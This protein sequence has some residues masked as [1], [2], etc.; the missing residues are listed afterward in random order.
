MSGV[1]ARKAFFNDPSLDMVEGYKILMGGAPL[2]EDI[3]LDVT[4]VE[5]TSV[6]IKRLLLLLRKDRITET[7]PVLLEDVNRRMMDWGRE[8]RINPFKEVYDLVFQMTVRMATCQEL[9]DDPKKIEELTQH[10]WNLEKSATPFA[11]L[12]PWFPGSSKR[13]KE[14][15]TLALYNLLLKLVQK[16]RDASSALDPIDI[17]IQNGDSDDAII[18]TILGIIF[19][20]VINTGVNSCWALLQL[21]TNPEWK[22]KAISELNAVITNHT[23]TLS[24]EPFHKQLASI[25]LSAWEEELPSLDLIIRETLRFTMTGAAIRR[26]LTND[27]EVN[28][29]SIKTGDF[30]TYSLY[31]AHMNPNIYS[32]PEKFDPSR[33]EK[34]REED[35]K[36]NFG[37]LGWGV[38][39]HPCA[40]MKIAK[41]EIKLILAM[42]LIGYD[43]TLVDKDDKYPMAL[44]KPD[45]NDIQQARPL[46]EPVYMKF[47]RVRD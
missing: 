36:E 6:F 19:A 27:I 32:E 25:P 43:Y 8:G 16:K 23:N 33:Y 20:G 14:K 42:L 21:G 5:G 44:P 35:K 12:L 47:K 13:M 15:S 7:L 11:L 24:T 31:D 39:R 46:G 18:G 30:L 3:D 10:Y 40:G 29:T 9:A 2:L 26:N 41:L 22:A 37:Y 17:L 28:G 38:G 34:G 45:R 4:K 1:Q